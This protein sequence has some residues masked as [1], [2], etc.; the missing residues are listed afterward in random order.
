MKLQ[1]EYDPDADSAY[2]RLSSEPVIESEEVSE[3]LMLDYDHAGKIVGIEVLQATTR[4]PR[5][6]LR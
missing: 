2:I 1:L 4:L 3:G 5:D 6:I